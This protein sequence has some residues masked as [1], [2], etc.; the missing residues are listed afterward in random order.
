VNVAATTVG[1]YRRRRLVR[2]QKRLLQIGGTIEAFAF[3]AAVMPRTWMEAAHVWLGMGTMPEGAVVDFMIRQS[4]FFYGMHGLL[5]WVLA[6]DVERFQPVVRFV[7]W[8]FL[9]F[10]PAFFV[11]DS[12]TGTPLWW[13]V[14]DPLACGL[15]GAA[16]LWVDRALSSSARPRRA[17]RGSPAG[18][19]GPG[20]R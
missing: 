7:G 2:A 14:C 5:L 15:Y 20:R 9:A 17:A 1:S 13:T 11:I 10:G 19:S 16:I 12:G 18:T 3:V 6:T 8:M 4:S